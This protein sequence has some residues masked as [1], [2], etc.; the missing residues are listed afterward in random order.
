MPAGGDK[1]REP[2]GMLPDCRREQVGGNHVERSREDRRSQ[3]SFKETNMPENVV[4]T[5][6]ALCDMNCHRIVVKRNNR[7][8][9]EPGRRDGQDAGPAANV[10]E[11]P[12]CP[13]GQPV[14]EPKACT[15]GAMLACPE[16]HAGIQLNDAITA[17][18]TVRFP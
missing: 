11:R 3:M 15:G 10:K 14:Y 8:A 1:S 16:A 12:W 17:S 9:T 13:A 18:R 4:S 7:P 2:D 5:R 6:I